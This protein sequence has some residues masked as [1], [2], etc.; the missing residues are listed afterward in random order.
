V[1]TSFS[2]RLPCTKLI[3]IEGATRRDVP[4]MTHIS[5]V[6][7]LASVLTLISSSVAPA[8]GK[9]GYAMSHRS[10]SCPRVLRMTLIFG[11]VLVRPAL[12]QMTTKWGFLP[13]RD[14][15]EL[16]Y[17]IS[18]PDHANPRLPAILHFAGSGF[19]TLIH[20]LLEPLYDGMTDLGFTV[21]SVN[22]RGIRRNPADL[23]KDIRDDVVYGRS[24]LHQLLADSED[25][26]RFVLADLGFKAQGVIA[27]GQSEGTVRGAWLAERFPDDVKALFFVGTQI[28]PPTNLIERQLLDDLAARTL[29][30]NDKDGDGRLDRTE[31][32]R[33]SADWVRTF[34]SRPLAECVPEGKD[35]LAL[36]DLVRLREEHFAKILATGDDHWCVGTLGVGIRFIRE[37]YELEANESR[38]M[39]VTCP[40]FFLSRREGRPVTGRRPAEVRTSCPAP[41]PLEFQ[42]LL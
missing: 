1:K 22:K 11:L 23:T 33:V 37:A 7:H 17:R 29:A 15:S 34:Y 10:L 42:I 31:C 26:I 38:L 36:E 4:A 14:G 16:E 32:G 25:I 27:F 39:R 30:E 20:P 19:S 21:I 18:A 13:T 8:M 40:V 35:S 28:A 3:S 6:Y 5:A 12:A 2:T 41:R 24:G 9:G